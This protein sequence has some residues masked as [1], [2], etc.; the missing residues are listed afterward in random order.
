MALAAEQNDEDPIKDDDDLDMDTPS[1][2]GRSRGRKRRAMDEEDDDIDGDLPGTPSSM[3]SSS[4]KSK[5]IEI[6]GIPHSV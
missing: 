5:P 1:R 3:A 4:A 2:G 6:P